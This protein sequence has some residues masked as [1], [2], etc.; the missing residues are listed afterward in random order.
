MNFYTYKIITTLFGDGIVRV[1]DGAGIPKDPNNCDY[2]AYLA[3]IEAGNIPEQ[4]N[5]T[6]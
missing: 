5:L 1:E 4:E 2:I 6:F 3:W